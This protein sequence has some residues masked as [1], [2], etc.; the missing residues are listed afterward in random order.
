M[1]L[2]LSLLIAVFGEEFSRLSEAQHKKDHRE[3]Q[4]G[5]LAAFHLLD[6]TNQGYITGRVLVDF[7]SHASF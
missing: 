3:I 4:T 1:F 2:I 5:M 7:L 6:Y